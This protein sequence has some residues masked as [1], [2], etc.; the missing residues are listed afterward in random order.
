MKVVV[1]VKIPQSGSPSLRHE[2]AQ[3]QVDGHLLVSILHTSKAKLKERLSEKQ[4]LGL[5]KNVRKGPS[6]W[7]GCRMQSEVCRECRSVFL[8][9]V[10]GANLGYRR[11]FSR[12]AALLN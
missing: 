9:P 5:D 4:T 1:G 7:K 6:H 11:Q 2:I 3:K 8:Q 10:M 12:D